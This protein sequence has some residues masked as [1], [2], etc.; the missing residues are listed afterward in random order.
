MVYFLKRPSM[1]N[2]SFSKTLW[3]A[4][5]SIKTK[6]CILTKSVNYL[7]P[8][9]MAIFTDLVAMPCPQY[10][11]ASARLTYAR[12]VITTL[13]LD[14]Y[15]SNR[16]VIDADGSAIR[17]RNTKVPD[18]GKCFLLGFECVPTSELCYLFIPSIL[19]EVISV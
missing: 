9:V 10:S 8:S 4:L 5:F 1:W 2:P 11:A 3:E 18:V 15:H 16:T 19:Q 14:E 12:H 13:W 7:N 17:V 6:A